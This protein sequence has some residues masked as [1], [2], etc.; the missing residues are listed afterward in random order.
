MN[1]S[2]EQTYIFMLS[3]DILVKGGPA[4]GWINEIEGLAEIQSKTG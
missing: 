3:S 1:S 4:P 2:I